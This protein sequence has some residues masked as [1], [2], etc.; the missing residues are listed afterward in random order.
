M[1][2]LGNH[3]RDASS[4]SAF[5]GGATS[6][7]QARRRGGVDVCLSRCIDLSTWQGGVDGCLDDVEE[8]H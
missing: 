1:A 6:L 2:S 4:P 5:H 8:M 3:E 7:Y